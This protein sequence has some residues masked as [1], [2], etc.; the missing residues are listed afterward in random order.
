[1]AGSGLTVKVKCLDCVLVVNLSVGM[2]DMKILI[3]Q[4]SDFLKRGPH[5]QHHLIDRMILRGHK[6][7]VIDYPILW[8][9]QG[10]KEIVSKRKVF[11]AQSKIHDKV[12]VTVIR[13]SIVKIPILDYI[14][15][16]F[17]HSKE[18]DRQIKEFKPDAIVGFGILNAYL[19]SGIA[20]K[21][22][23]PFVYYWIDVLHQLI[24]QKF[25]QIVGKIFEQM[26]L[27]QSD[28][29]L[30]INQS[31]RDYV[32][33]LGSD[34]DKTKVIT[35]GVDIEKFNPKAKLVDMR[36]KYGFKKNDIVL[37]FMG[38][39]YRFS[40]LV[41]VV[42]RLDNE[43]DKRIKLLIVGGGDAF[44][45]LKNIK[46]VFMQDNLV[47]TG[48]MPYTDIPSLINASDIC[49]LPAYTDE[50]TMQSIVPI[51][52]YE[53]LAMGKPVISTNLQGIIK[54]FGMLNGIVYTCNAEEVVDRAKELV[55]GK[56][57]RKLSQR[58]LAFAKRHSWERIADEFE[59]LLANLVALNKSVNG[60]GR[61]EIL[62]RLQRV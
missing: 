19:A 59:S 14:S 11:F 3:V 62:G 42:W 37:F 50:P 13:P 28:I 8:K 7:R 54:E 56:K 45:E 17:T 27:K 9:E 18:I 10:R 16:L 34:P 44:G 29:V 51:K 21:N 58:A 55:K 22:N 43:M 23:I 31:L 26:T 53:Y 48:W 47:L 49:I 39:L 32:I 24:P 33:S 25:L 57:L 20:K 15:I 5:Q 2:T 6:V 40:G 1:M 60:R 35:A 61:K 46:S 52:V 4:E 30:T 36:S 41:E 38:W 12:K